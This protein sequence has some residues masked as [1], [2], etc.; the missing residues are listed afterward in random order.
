MIIKVIFT[1]IIYNK[2]FRQINK[3]NSTHFC[4]ENM[5]SKYQYSNSFNDENEESYKP[6]L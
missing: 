5:K 4:E 3:L 1:Y 2:K 6:F